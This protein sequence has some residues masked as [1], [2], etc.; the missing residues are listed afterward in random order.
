MRRLRPAALGA[1]LLGGAC[2]P[3]GGG[4][5]P[6]IGVA[7][8]TSSAALDA[9]R[10]GFFR[11]LADSGYVRD[12]TIKVIE[13]NAQGDIATLMLI[14]NEFKQRGVDYVTTVSSVAT[15]AALRVISSQ[16]IVFA[17]V[18]NPYIIGA[19]TSATEHKP[20]VTGANIPLPVDSAF[21]LAREAFPSIAVWGS[22]YDPADPFAE[23]YLEVARAMAR[24]LG[25]EFIAVACTAPGDI[26]PGIQA[27]KAKGVGGILQLP[28]VMIGGGMAAVIKTARQIG[29]ALVTP[30]TD[31]AG[32]PLALGL[33]FYN[34]GY[35]AGLLMI[36][37][38]RGEKPADLPF[39]AASKRR[40]VVDLDAA[41][42]F[43]LS[44]PPSII[45]RADSVVGAR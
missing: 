42:G 11:A 9:A 21:A 30:N 33:S 23:Y 28:S 34:N 5:R 12:S 18:A 13:R 29:L 7:Q 25:V 36:R 35:D 2:G 43:G 44:I 14:M 27:L 39:Q 16:P 31:Y 6:V 1:L 32:V 19:G 4:E 24:R 15:Q 3:L 8:I 22:L 20:H 41:R 10:D 17:A 26:A 40:M 37:V 38:I 45:A